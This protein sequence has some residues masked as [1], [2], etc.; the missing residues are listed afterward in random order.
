MACWQYLLTQSEFSEV[1]CSLANRILNK[2]HMTEFEPVHHTW[3]TLL[4]YPVKCISYLLD[5][6]WLAFFKKWICLLNGLTRQA[7]LQKL[8]QVSTASLSKCTFRYFYHQ[9]VALSN[10]LCWNSA[11]C[12]F[13]VGCDGCIRDGQ[14]LRCTSWLQQLRILDNTLCWQ[15]SH[16]SLVKKWTKF[17]ALGTLFSGSYEC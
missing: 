9:S 5:S 7:P 14:H 11:H 13:A 1:K 16:F 12:E 4:L 2:F 8:L 15:G 6:S 10:V 17:H 3:K